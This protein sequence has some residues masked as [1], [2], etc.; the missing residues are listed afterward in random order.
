MH[1]S[2]CEVEFQAGMS[3]RFTQN[4][5]ALSAY[6]NTYVVGMENVVSRAVREASEAAGSQKKKRKKKKELAYICKENM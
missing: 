6:T 5:S 3:T 1:V 4:T 2:I